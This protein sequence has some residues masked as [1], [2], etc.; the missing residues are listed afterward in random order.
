M[1]GSW[2]NS[3]RRPAIISIMDSWLGLIRA[4]SRPWSRARV[5]KARLRAG[6]FGA[7]KELAAGGLGSIDEFVAAYQAA[8][9]AVIDRASLHWWLV[10]ATLRWGVMCRY[11]YE[12]HRTGQ[13]RSVELAAIGRRVCETE[14]DLLTLLERT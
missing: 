6:R 5:K 7:P 11:Q 1:D 13:T 8:G 9:G 10:L 2:F 12:R 3:T 14:Y 4:R